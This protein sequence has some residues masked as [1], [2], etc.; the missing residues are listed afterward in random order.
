MK[1]SSFL[2]HEIKTQLTIMA[3]AALMMKLNRPQPTREDERLIQRILTCVR[4]ADILVSS[5]EKGDAWFDECVEGNEAVSLEEIVQG[6]VEQFS[7]DALRKNIALTIVAT[8][9]KES[10]LEKKVEGPSLSPSGL[11]DEGGESGVSSGEGGKGGDGGHGGEGGKG[12]K[13]GPGGRGGDGGDG[14]QGLAGNN[15][16]AGGHG[17]KGGDGDPGNDES[18]NSPSAPEN[19]KPKSSAETSHES[20]NA[21][22]ADVQQSSAELEPSSGIER[23]HRLSVELVLTNLLQNA[24]KYTHKD[25]HVTL[26]YGITPKYVRFI[27]E[28]DGPDLELGFLGREFQRGHRSDSAENSNEPGQGFGLAL[29]ARLARR[30]GGHLSAKNL[31]PHGCRFEFDVPRS[32]S[33]PLN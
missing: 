23:L 5:L 25:G 8:R 1:T 32:T 17:G 18:S 11:Q 13:A 31:V 30:L 10:A 21:A 19:L 9:A 29:S 33:A 2:A 26:N 6:V 24:M 16:G 28:N 22:D 14:G 27:V 12:G 3:G 4:R 15:G 20:S 7:D